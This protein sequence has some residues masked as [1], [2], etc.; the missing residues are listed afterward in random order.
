MYYNSRNAEKLEA[1]AIR[2]SS[3]TGNPGFVSTIE[4]QKSKTSG[5][6]WCLSN[7]NSQAIAAYS[8]RVQKPGRYAG[9]ELKSVVKDWT[10]IQT[11]FALIFPDIYDIGVP[12]LG[13][14]ILYET[15]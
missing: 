9:G 8:P 13:I 15:P 6:Y 5:A 7:R 14:M 4:R 2:I 12:N 1:T 3:K 11:S 10:A